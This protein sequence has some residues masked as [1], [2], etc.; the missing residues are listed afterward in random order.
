LALPNGLCDAYVPELLSF[1]RYGKEE[2]GREKGGEG[3]A[4]I[5]DTALLSWEP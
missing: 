4:S 3:W 5:L 1:Q 2:G